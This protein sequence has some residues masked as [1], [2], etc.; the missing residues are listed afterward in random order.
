M[1]KAVLRDNN[2]ADIIIHP[3]VNTV[4]SGKKKWTQRDKPLEKTV[5]KDIGGR[6]S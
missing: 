2:D 3:R 4:V 1:Y 6:D 5:H